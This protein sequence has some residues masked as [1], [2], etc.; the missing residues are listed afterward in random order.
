MRFR[1]WMIWCADAVPE[2][3]LRRPHP[4]SSSPLSTHVQRKVS[5]MV[6]FSTTTLSASRI[7]KV[8]SF[9]LTWKNATR[10]YYYQSGQATMEPTRRVSWTV[11]NQIDDATKIGMCSGSLDQKNR[12]PRSTIQPSGHSP[13]SILGS[14]FSSD[15][16]TICWTQ[17]RCGRAFATMLSEARPTCKRNDMCA[18]TRGYSIGPQKWTTRTRSIASLMT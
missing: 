15:A 6:Q 12:A 14:M 18:S 17:R 1:R 7:T 8:S 13:R 2:H 9:G 16:L 4:P 3:E 5:S 11:P 10:I